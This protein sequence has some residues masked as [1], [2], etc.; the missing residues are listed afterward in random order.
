MIVIDLVQL[1]RLHPLL[2]FSLL[3]AMSNFFLVFGPG[4]ARHLRQRGEVAARRRKFESAKLPDTE[5][6]HR[7]ASCGKTEHDDPELE[8]RV[9]TDGEEYCVDHLPGRAAD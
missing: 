3:L 9:A 7:C 4:T 8:F 5:A 1:V 6:L 2:G